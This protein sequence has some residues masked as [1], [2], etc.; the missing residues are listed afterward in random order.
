M[1]LQVVPPPNRDDLASL[2]GEDLSAERT[3]LVLPPGRVI[4]G[5]V[6]DGDGKRR[7][8]ARARR[9]PEAGDEPSPGD[10]RAGATTDDD[11]TFVLRGL[12]RA[13][14][15]L[16]ADGPDARPWEDDDRPFTTVDAGTSEV[17]LVLERAARVTVR[18]I[19]PDGAPVR[20]ADCAVSSGARTSAE[21][22]DDGTFDVPRRPTKQVVAV[23][24]AVAADG[25]SPAPGL[26][27]VNPGVDVVELRLAA[28]AE[29]RGRVVDGDGKPV[30]GARVAVAPR[31]VPSDEVE[32]EAT[33]MLERRSG[34]FGNAVRA[35]VRSTTG[36]TARSP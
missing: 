20:S 26:V 14:V 10:F 4:R 30:A 36:G 33:A 24:R 28:G 9:A 29:V 13:P 18:V 21:T 2:D 34:P 25:T 32:R 6:V 22:I 17:R 19:G 15:L 1:G 11:G 3:R 12:P 5:K 16:R 7:G 27:T 23:A 8:E 31:E 35:L